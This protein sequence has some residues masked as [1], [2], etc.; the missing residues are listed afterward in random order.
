MC[1]RCERRSEGCESV[2]FCCSFFFWAEFGEV[3][4]LGCLYTYLQLVSSIHVWLPVSLRTTDSTRF[5]LQTFSDESSF[6]AIV[7]QP[8]I[9]EV[10]CADTE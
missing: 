3:D 6:L 2:I 10:R 1:K 5:F 8:F 9:D 7:Q 4:S